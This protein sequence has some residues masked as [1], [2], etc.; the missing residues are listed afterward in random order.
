VEGPPHFVVACFSCHPERS[1]ARTLR[2]TQSKDP[3]E[4]HPTSTLRPFLPQIP[5][6]SVCHSAAPFC[7]SFR[8]TL[9]F[10]IPQHP[11]VC[12]SAA[13]FCLSFRSTLFFV[14]P[15]RSGGICCCFFARHSGAEPGS[16]AS[17]LAGV[18]AR[19]SVSALAVASAFRRERRASAL[20]IIAPRKR[21]ALALGRID[22]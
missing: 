6:S 19:I 4:L 13:P 3:D 1:L 10:V 11:F 8:S 20:R 16:P 2:Q 21:R 18:E 5:G 15:Q 14:I 7:L 12:H 9:L 22:I 17:L